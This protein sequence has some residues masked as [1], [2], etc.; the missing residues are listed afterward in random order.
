MTQFVNDLLPRGITAFCSIYSFQI[1]L[2]WH[3]IYRFKET[4]PVLMKKTIL[5]NL[6]VILFYY[7][8]VWIIALFERSV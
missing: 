2:L 3:N 6:L 1:A 8:V 7:A 4:N 5:V